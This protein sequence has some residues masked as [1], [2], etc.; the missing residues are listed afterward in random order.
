[1][2]KDKRVIALLVVVAI[3]S[4]VLGGILS[5][6]AVFGVEVFDY[7]DIFASALSEIERNY[8][9]R[10]EVKDLVHSAIKGMMG[11]LDEYSE[12]M[13][14]EIY[15]QFTVETRGRFGGLGIQIAVD[16]KDGVLTIIAPIEDTLAYRMGIKSGDK[17]IEIEGNPTEGMTISE[18][19]K[20]LRGRPGTS[21]N[22]TV[23]RDEE[24]IIPFVIT[25][26]IIRI[27][28][29]K[30]EDIID[31]EHKIGYVR[32]VEFRENV[33]DELNK[34][35]AKLE[36]QG[37]KALIF[38]LRNNP[39]GLLQSAIEV[40]S[41]FIDEGELVVT[42]K[43]RRPGHNVRGV[44]RG[45][46]RS[47]YPLVIL[48][49]KGSASASEIV[50][51]AIQDHK[52]GSIVGEQSFG[53]GSVQT[54]MSLKDGS[55]LRITTAKWFTPSGNPIHGEG[56]TPDVVVVLPKLSEQERQAFINL[57][58]GS[59]IET[60]LDKYPSPT[61]ENISELLDELKGEDINLTKELIV[62]QIRL[63][64]DIKEDDVLADLQLMKA[65]EVLGNE[66]MGK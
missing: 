56:I 18:A 8:V 24:D 37:M 54:V 21:V 28:S 44:A 32:L 64:N 3:V 25:R 34:A 43:G 41:I 2:F 22:I 47:K 23:K 30:N 57:R 19:V 5:R 16:P 29:V 50:A 46:P 55:G 39:G 66:Q 48:I 27:E 20:V 38:D 63:A 7:L 62:N 4:S 14:P 65:I 60:F 45:K 35:L 31:E 10:L 12:F 42:T 26:D 53:K 51:G 40:S 36:R 6:G 11:T 13:A 1:M 59:Y 49:N 9:E 58:N 15:R 17:I 52:R 33:A 61:E